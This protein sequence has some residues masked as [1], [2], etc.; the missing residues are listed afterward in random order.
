L[1]QTI[2]SVL[3]LYGWIVAA[4]L[5]LF[6]YLIGRYYEIQIGRKSRYQLFLLPLALFLVAAVWYVFFARSS[7]GEPLWDF[8]GVFW[9]DLV[10]LLAGLSMI[11]LCYSLH[12]TMM[13]GKR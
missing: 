8:V 7:A 13:G 6:L 4:I 9:P 3:V 1:I 5:I 12:R 2:N 10:F 11:V